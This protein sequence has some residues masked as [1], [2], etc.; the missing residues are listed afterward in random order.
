MASYAHFRCA[1]RLTAGWALVALFT[2]VLRSSSP[3]GFENG[4]PRCLLYDASPSTTSFRLSRWK[5]QLLSLPKKF[6]A[7]TSGFITSGNPHDLRRF[8][9][10]RRI[11]S[12]LKLPSLL[13]SRNFLPAPYCL[14]PT[15]RLE[16]Q[17]GWFKPGKGVECDGPQ[18]I[19]DSGNRTKTNRT[20]NS[21]GI[22]EWHQLVAG[23]ERFRP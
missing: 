13:D 5:V 6:A 4:V 19:Q 16:V 17:W 11:L 12:C 3:T 23:P 14:S 22:L 1:P 20:L 21:P 7:S 8:R 2:S 18:S 10:R 9:V 15:L